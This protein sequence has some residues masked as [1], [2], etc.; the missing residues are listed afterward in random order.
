ML[1]QDSTAALADL[2]ELFGR[3]RL[4]VL[5]EAALVRHVE[6]ILG[7]AGIGYLR[8]HRLATGHRL[9]FYLPAPRL[10]IETKVA[11]TWGTVLRQVEAYCK[12]PETAGGL[13]ITRRNGHRRMPKEIHGKP[14]AVLWAGE[15]VP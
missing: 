15:F 5:S 6:L 11:E 14:L 7:G 10:F 9:D 4:P 3:Y 2:V 12:A 13:L 1:C 8:E